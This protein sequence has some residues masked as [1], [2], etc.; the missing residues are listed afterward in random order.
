MSLAYICDDYIK[1]RIIVIP[2]FSCHATYTLYIILV[3]VLLILQT[4]I[5]YNIGDGTRKLLT[6][7]VMFNGAK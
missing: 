6:K 5:I 7:S 2:S 4:T 1:F 3:M